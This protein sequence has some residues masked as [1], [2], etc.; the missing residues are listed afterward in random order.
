MALLPLGRDWRTHFLLHSGETPNKCNQ[1]D[2]SLSRAG[3]L[4]TNFKIHS[5]E[6]NK[7][8]DSVQVCLL[9]GRIYEDTLEN[10]QLFTVS[11]IMHVLIQVL[12]GH[13]WKHTVEKSQANADNVTMP[14]LMQGVWCPIWK[15]T[16]EKSQTNAI[17]VIIHPLKQL[18]WGD[19]WKP[20]V[21]KSK[22]NATNVIMH[23][24]SLWITCSQFEGTFVKDA[25]WQSETTGIK[26]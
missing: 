7:Q 1:C 25:N 4:R 16:V 23:S 10:T 17:S 24:H 3:N 5:W 13:I 26:M 12:W 11:G 21:K 22:T 15:I 14:S 19:I 18:I 20:T 8:M 9:Q 6:Q 2:Y